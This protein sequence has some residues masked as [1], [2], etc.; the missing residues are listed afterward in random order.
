M[1]D[2]GG[3]VRG[4]AVAVLTA[5]VVLA[6][7]P[8]ASAADCANCHRL[9]VEGPSVS[10]VHA[11]YRRK[12]CH[13]C[14]GVHPK[15]GGLV[16][17]R[18]GNAICLKCHEKGKVSFRNTHDDLPVE[19]ISCLNCHQPHYSDKP[20]LLAASLHAPLLTGKCRGCHKGGGAF[21]GATLA[22][23][24]FGCHESLSFKGPSGHKPAATGMCDECHDPHGSKYP[25]LLT[26]AYPYDRYVPYTSER[27]GLCFKCHEPKGIVQEGGEADTGFKDRRVNLH[28]VHV[29]KREVSETGQVTREGMSCRNCH[30]PHSSLFPHLV[31][32]DL[33][34]GGG[35]L[36]L[37]MA[38]FVRSG[39]GTCKGG[40]HQTMSY[41][42]LEEAVGLPVSPV[43]G[44]RLPPPAQAVYS[45]CLECHQDDWLRFQRRSIHDPVQ[46]KKCAGC[47][48]EHGSERRL[49]FPHFGSKLCA[50]CHDGSRKSLVASHAG[51]DVTGSRCLSC[52]DPHASDEKRLLKAGAHAPFRDRSCA[53]CHDASGGSWKLSRAINKTC[54]KCHK[55][56]LAPERLHSG[57]TKGQCTGC[58]DP[59]VGRLIKQ[60]TSLVPDLCYRCHDRRGFEGKKR[61]EPAA[62]GDCL[63][64]HAVHGRAG[65][66]LLLKDGNALCL[67]CH[68]TGRTAFK[69]RHA[70]L[71][72]EKLS[73]LA[74]H[75][76]H[77]SETAGL[78]AAGVHTPLARGKC[79]DCHDEGAGPAGEA[80]AE[81]CRRC[82]D[83]PSFKG[84][85]TH[86]PVAEGRCGQCHDPHGSR[87]PFLLVAPYS[88]ERYAAFS[89]GAY[90]LCF[91]CHKA[92]A[93]AA[94]GDARIT[95]F[96]DRE[97]NL[98][99][100]HV[101]KTEGIKG[102][103]AA[104]QGLSCRNCHQPHT[105]LSPHLIR[106]DLD[107]GG[108]VKCL[109]LDYEIRDGSGNCTGSCHQAAAYPAGDD[110][111][112]RQGKAGDP[113]P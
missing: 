78:L 87:F 80:S 6:A 83:T 70:R 111:G 76:P 10:S 22:A 11:P 37:Q 8:P 63:A 105:S 35:V 2:L 102:R 1:A 20:K 26:A 18:E 98:H 109:K 91:K 17:V 21:T 85:V 48:G 49:S 41:S 95:G 108:G 53:G 84:P 54:A 82:H 33:D 12:N 7:A 72:V 90:G 65:E 55:E 43:E 81:L 106:Q 101:V 60:L 107:C 92:E 77:S 62:K 74:C 34:C 44:A 61:H 110:F 14:H 79:R 93:F 52:H 36:C 24:C 4:C 30:E 58:H 23:A 71:P 3:V 66:S 59:H 38:Y 39:T 51:M 112:R 73:C 5:G 42:P 103:A 75:D 99:Y 50:E 68:D 56:K 40:C 19:K 97:T 67:G 100:T 9:V 25:F 16:L 28:Q 32:Q 96:R 57:I 15:E 64:C 45:P 89:P 27:Y 69:G 104:R 47:H 88:K 94:A 13:A 86:K 29:V 31:R 46:K 113:S